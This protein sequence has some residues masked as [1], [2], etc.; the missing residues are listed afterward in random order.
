MNLV[1]STSRHAHHTSEEAE[2]RS[3]DVSGMFS[4]TSGSR[5]PD[6][7]R[8]RDGESA[9]RA[10]YGTRGDSFLVGQH[11]AASGELSSCRIG[12]ILVS[13]FSWKPRESESGIG[14]RMRLV[15]V[16]WQ[17]DKVR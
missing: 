6:R 17:R 9:N 10:D 2:N 3:S 5:K 15:G 8:R 16:A 11:S 7:N 12:S 14:V 13:Y 1:E 4:G